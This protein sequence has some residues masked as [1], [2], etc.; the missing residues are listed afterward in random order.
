MLS[1]PSFVGAEEAQKFD[2]KFGLGKSLFQKSTTTVKQF[3]AVMGQELTQIQTSTFYAKQTPLRKEGDSW[4]IEHEIEGIA[5][6][7]DISGNKIVFDSTKPDSELSW[8]SVNRNFASM[9]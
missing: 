8:F 4:V 3:I 1:T 5:L 9:S 2:L 7:I 6:T